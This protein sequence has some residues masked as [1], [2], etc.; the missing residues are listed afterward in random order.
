MIKLGTEVTVKPKDDK[1]Y[2]EVKSDQGTGN[3]ELAYNEDCKKVDISEEIE[4]KLSLKYMNHFAKACSF[5]KS[6]EIRMK[7]ENPIIIE[8]PLTRMSGCL[9]NADDDFGSILFFLAPK[10]GGDD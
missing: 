3:F 10:I 9:I 8:F 4:Q 5:C 1:I 7:D 6:V 2:F